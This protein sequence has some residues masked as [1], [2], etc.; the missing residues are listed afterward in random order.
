MPQSVGIIG[1]KPKQS[2]WFVGFQGVL[3]MILNYLPFFVTHLILD[4][5][6]IF[7]DPHI[8]QE[9]VQPNVKFSDEVI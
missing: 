1:G 4:E 5:H 3:K 6:L 8:V 9:S 2:F 7:L